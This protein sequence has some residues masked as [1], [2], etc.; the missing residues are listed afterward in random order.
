MSVGLWGPFSCVS[1][2]LKA[3]VTPLAALS[4]HSD[5]RTQP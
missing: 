5:V 2:W 3:L 4:T 1:P